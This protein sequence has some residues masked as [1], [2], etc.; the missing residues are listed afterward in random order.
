MFLM[1]VYPTSSSSSEDSFVSRTCHVIENVYAV[2][3]EYMESQ[4]R[5]TAC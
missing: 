3:M 1:I 4:T 2:Y 5:L